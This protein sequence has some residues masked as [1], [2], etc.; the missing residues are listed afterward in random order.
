MIVIDEIIR[1]PAGRLLVG[2]PYMLRLKL[3]ETETGGEL[4]PVPVVH[5]D[6]PLGFADQYTG[7]YYKSYGM[8]GTMWFDLPTVG[9]HTFF[10]AAQRA[11]IRPKQD[12]DYIALTAGQ[13]RA[14][15]SL[16]GLAELAGKTRDVT[17]TIYAEDGSAAATATVTDAQLGVDADY[18][19]VID[20]LTLADDGN[21]RLYFDAPIMSG[22]PLGFGQ[23]L[24]G[25][26]LYRMDVST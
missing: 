7:Q 6:I 25:L 5:V 23:F 20:G 1:T 15:L 18:M 17:A 4:V 11:Q 12:T 2:A 3:R 24:Y 10:A 26:D 9:D 19:L 22:A 14:T 13:Y 21:Y 16:R 8:L